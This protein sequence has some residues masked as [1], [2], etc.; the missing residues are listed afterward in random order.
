MPH[1][2]QRHDLLKPWQEHRLTVCIPHLDTPELL[3][4]TVRLWQLQWTTPFILVLDTGSESEKS[5]AVLAGLA[6]Q[7]G[8]EV[9]RLNRSQT[10]G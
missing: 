3:A 7:P 6:S 8:I 10:A 1:F 2:L 9:A 5:K 4:A